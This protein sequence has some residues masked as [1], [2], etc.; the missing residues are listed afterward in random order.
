MNF[1]KMNNMLVK[2]KT[3]SII[4]LPSQINIISN[5]EATRSEQTKA[6][7]IAADSQIKKIKDANKVFKDKYIFYSSS[8]TS[9]VD[10]SIKENKM[11]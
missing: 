4:K 2:L 5:Q 10:C 6:L 8:I 3:V 1:S 7:L 11:C 9:G